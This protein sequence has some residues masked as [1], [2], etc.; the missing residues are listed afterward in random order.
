MFERIKGL[1]KRQKE[2][3]KPPEKLFTQEYWLS[4]YER[5]PQLAVTLQ[6][7]NRCDIWSDEALNALISDGYEGVFKLQTKYDSGRK[8]FL[9]DTFGVWQH[10]FLEASINGN[11]YI[12]DGT[13]NQFFDEETINPVGYFGI[14][15]DAPSRLQMIY[16]Y[17][18]KESKLPCA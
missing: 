17:N 18:E 16:N 14:V 7:P 10:Q 6:T 9:W 8:T 4:L 5:Y 3:V 11:R 1:I 15:E 13:A 12:A 2:S